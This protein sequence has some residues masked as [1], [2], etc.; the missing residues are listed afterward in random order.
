[1]VCEIQIAQSYLQD[2]AY[3]KAWASMVTKVDGSN[4]KRGPGISPEKMA[5][6]CEAAEEYLGKVREIL[7]SK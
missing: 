2:L 4:W 3:E 7:E 1:M 5:K 6:I